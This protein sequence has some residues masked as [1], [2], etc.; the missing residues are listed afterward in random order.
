[1]ERYTSYHSGRV[2]LINSVLDPIPIYSLSFYKSLSKVLHEIR[3]TQSSILWSD[4]KNKKMVHWVNWNTV[5]KSREKGGLGV[6][7]IEMMNLALLN[8]WKWRIM[9]EQEIVLSN[10][11]IIRYRNLVFKVLI[12]DKSVLLNKDSIWMRG[13]VMSDNYV[14]NLANR[15]AGAVLCYVKNGAGT[16]FWHSSG[17]EIKNM[18]EAL[19]PKNTH[20]LHLFYVC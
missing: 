12:E 9:S 6:K 5:C 4:C 15:F 7:D 16:A 20:F 17:W 19:K 8:K 14:V 2:V 18:L 1:M 11:L 13:L 10:I 3:H